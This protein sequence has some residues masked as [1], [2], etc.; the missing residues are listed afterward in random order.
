MPRRS[1]VPEES[2]A[3]TARTVLLLKD[4]IAWMAA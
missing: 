3:A 4:P 1:F 2:I